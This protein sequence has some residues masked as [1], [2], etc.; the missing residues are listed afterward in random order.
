MK[1][2]QDA[3]LGP[4]AHVNADGSNLP[5]DAFPTFLIAQLGN[6]VRRMVTAPYA[7][8]HGLTISEWRMLA[9][10]GQLAPIPFGVLVSLSTS[11]KA[12]VSRTIRA[13]QERGLCQS[14]RK[15]G[16]NNKRIVCHLTPAGREL[17]EAVMP[18]AR[19]SQ[20]KLLS[21]LN[22]EERVILFR[23]IMKLHRACTGSDIIV[24]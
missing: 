15:P 17:Y 3:A 16:G 20:A 2:T 12:L 23:S 24:R 9:L 8:A 19:K 6:A 14:Q 18:M 10:M 21:V 22:E 4:W 5:V 7:E 13:L 1:S 11:D